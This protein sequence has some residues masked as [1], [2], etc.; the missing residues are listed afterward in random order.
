MITDETRFEYLS[1]WCFEYKPMHYDGCSYYRF[2][3]KN[4]FSELSYEEF[5]KK[6]DDGIIT[7]RQYFVDGKANGYH[8]NLQHSELVQLFYNFLQSDMFNKGKY[9]YNDYF[10]FVK[11]SK[12]KKEVEQQLFEFLRGKSWAERH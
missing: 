8:P 10:E 4:R 2:Y 1:E 5:I 9:S 3:I 7:A 12:K 6:I 11:F